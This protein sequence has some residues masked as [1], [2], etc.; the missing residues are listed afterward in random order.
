MSPPIP[1]RPTFGL[2]R[3]GRPRSH[4]LLLSFS[5]NVHPVVG[6]PSHGIPAETRLLAPPSRGG[7][8]PPPLPAS[9]RWQPGPAARRPLSACFSRRA[10][11]R[12]SVRAHPSARPQYGV[13]LGV[14][15]AGEG[16]G[17][18]CAFS[19][20]CLLLQGQPSRDLRPHSPPGVFG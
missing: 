15:D 6:T 4:V 9:L 17:P 1:G 5:R 2:F 20:P 18:A 10:G 3:A 7:P 8:A 16:R 12:V 14:V 19:M 11:P 13:F